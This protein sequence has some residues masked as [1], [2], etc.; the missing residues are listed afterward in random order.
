MCVC[1]CVCVCARAR[2]VQCGLW[3]HIVS[4]RMVRWRVSPTNVYDVIPLVFSA[5][6]ISV[7]F[8]IFFSKLLCSC[9]LVTQLCLTLCDP[10]G[11]NALGFCVLMISRSLVKLMSVESMMPSNH[12]IL[13]P[14]SPPA[15]K[16]SQ[17]QGLFQR[18]VSLHQ[19]TRVSELQ[20]QH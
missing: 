14:P 20:L 16:L 2:A 6:G 9:G 19:V 18:V 12:L 1:V 3:D 4:V 7:R 10:L 15:L 11:C 17:H 13:S 5:P 8:L